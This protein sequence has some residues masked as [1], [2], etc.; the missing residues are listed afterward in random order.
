MHN[1]SMLAYPFAPPTRV[2]PEAH[3]FIWPQQAPK[4]DPSRSESS[5]QLVDFFKIPKILR[6]RF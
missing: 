4:V 1:L 5:S 3:K 6:T 2:A